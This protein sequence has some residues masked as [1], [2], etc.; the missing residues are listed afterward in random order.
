LNRQ[1]ETRPI[2]AAF[3]ELMRSY[4]PNMSATVQNIVTELSQALSQQQSCLDLS[5]RGKAL[6]KELGS[7]SIIGDGKVPTP[8]V[9]RGNQLYLHR[10]YQYESSVAQAL[11]ACNR[12]LPLHDHLE[13][14]LQKYFGQASGT[15]NWQQIAALQSQAQQLTIITGGPGTGKTSTVAKIISMLR[16]NDAEMVIKLAAPTGKAAR[17]LAESI[18]QFLPQLPERTRDT[19]PTRVQTLHRLL[20]MRSDGRSF[21]YNR[22]N[23]ITADVIVIDEVSMIDLTMMHRLLDAL[24]ADTRLLLLGDPDQLPS[25]EAGNVLAD[26]C[27]DRPGFSQ[28]FADLTNKMLAVDLPVTKNQHGLTNAICHFETNYRF[29]MDQGIGQLANNIQ[30]GEPHLQSSGDDEVSVYNLE[31]LAADRLR[32]EIAS[33]YFEY[34]MLLQDPES[35]AASLLSN[36]E[37]TRILCPV[38]DGDLG[39]ETLNSEMESYLE[40]KGLKASD[41]SFYHGRPLIIMQNDYNLGLFNGDIGICVNDPLDNQIKTAFMDPQGEIRLYLASRLPP[42]ESCF[43]MTVHKSQG[44]EFN[45]VTLIMPRPTS[46]PSEQLLTRELIYTAV[47]RARHS[48]AIYADDITWSEA[49]QRSVRRMSGLSSMLEFGEATDTQTD[50]FS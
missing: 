46:A 30:S 40:E 48:M 11:I 16:E 50:L 24:P 19:I 45:H 47:T 36:F 31:S 23:L 5:G 14:Q 44:S 18:L 9:L 39:V 33:Y 21:R 3:S 12:T 26:L 49:L 28:E 42:H 17:R 15:V 6:I 32:P 1:I 2:D 38:R 13:D 27:R 29:S 7:L 37:S 25:I 22:D 4:S 20:G 10:Y 41:Q 8:L 34:E 43:A 35:D